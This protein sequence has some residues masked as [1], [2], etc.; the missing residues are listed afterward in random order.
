M[1][2]PMSRLARLRHAEP[3]PTS[4]SSI[5]QPRPNPSPKVTVFEPLP[6]GDKMPLSDS[7][8]VTT[9]TRDEIASASASLVTISAPKDGTIQSTP[10]TPDPIKEEA[11]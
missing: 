1:T 3:Q 7:A 2:D 4:I 11:A 6:R 5:G 9:T 8:A 10:T